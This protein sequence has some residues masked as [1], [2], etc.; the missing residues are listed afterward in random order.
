MGQT[1]QNGEKADNPSGLHEDSAQFAP[2]RGRRDLSGRFARTL[3]RSGVRLVLP[4]GSQ[5]EE[6]DQAG[7][8]RGE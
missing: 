1:G 6:E 2:R 4:V 8:G 5:F 7:K 3:G